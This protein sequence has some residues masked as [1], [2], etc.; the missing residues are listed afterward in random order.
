MYVFNQAAMVRKETTPLTPVEKASIESEYAELDVG[1]FL[2]RKIEWDDDK[3]EALPFPTK[4]GMLRPRV[5]PAASNP[6]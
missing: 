6:K 2:K 1:S 5:L 4:L 3:E